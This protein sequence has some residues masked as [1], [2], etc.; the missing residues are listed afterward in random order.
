M[1]HVPRFSVRIAGSSGLVV[2]M[3]GDTAVACVG[4]PLF[5]GGSD[6]LAFAPVFLVGSDIPD[7]GMEANLVVLS[8]P[9]LEFGS[10]HVDV[11][12]AFQ[13]GVLAFEVP[14]QRLD[15]CLVGGGARPAVVG[16]EPGERHELSCRPRGH[17]GAV[18]LSTGVKALFEV[19]V[20]VMLVW[21]RA[22]PRSVQRLLFRPARFFAV[23]GW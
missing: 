3:V 23:D 11:L 17:L 15:P 12:D 2:L 13:V 4:E 18:E 22:V 21:E 16:G 9:D 1:S 14:E 7:A 10:E 8:A 5:A 20:G 19:L 6:R